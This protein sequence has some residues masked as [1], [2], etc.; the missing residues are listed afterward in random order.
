MITKQHPEHEFSGS[1][2]NQR[3]NQM[4]MAKM[5]KNTG[6]D[7]AVQGHDHT[8]TAEHTSSRIMRTES[9]PVSETQ[10]NISVGV[11]ATDKHEN[12]TGVEKK[13]EKYIVYEIYK[14]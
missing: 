10:Q 4:P 5:M 11:Q 13:L 1:R 12:Q 3:S 14:K 9:R 7:G 2:S 8:N 6:R